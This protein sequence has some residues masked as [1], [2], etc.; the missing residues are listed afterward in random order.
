MLQ[1]SLLAYPGNWGAW[2]ELGNVCVCACVLVCVCVCVC[3]CACVRL[4]VHVYRYPVPLST[5]G[6][7]FEVARSLDESLF[8]GAHGSGVA[9]QQA[10]IY[11]CV[12]NVFITCSYRDTA[13]E[14]QSN[15]QAYKC[16]YI[17]FVCVFAC[18]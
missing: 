4:H 5:G 14:L 3:V 18:V 13:L 10:G 1:E 7:G 11:M 2:L 17:V 16:V 8:H 6:G 9:E 15:K 12:H